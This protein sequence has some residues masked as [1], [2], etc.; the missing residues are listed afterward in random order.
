MFTSVRD[1][2]VADAARAAGARGYLLKDVAPERLA[3]ALQRV[4]AGELAFPNGL[5]GTPA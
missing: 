5:L 3:E 1:G 2:D 4:L